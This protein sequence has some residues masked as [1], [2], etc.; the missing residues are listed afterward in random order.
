[1]KEILINCGFIQKKCVITENGEICDVLV[2]HSDGVGGVGNI[3]KGT[4]DNIVPGMQSA[5]IDIGLD[6][7]AFLFASDIVGFNEK[8]DIRKKIKKGDTLTV[9]IVKEAQGVKGARV[10]ENI[11]LPGH[12]LVLMPFMSHIGISKK[13]D[14]ESEKERLHIIVSSLA[15]SN[16]G[17]IVRTD[18]CGATEEELKQEIDYLEEQWEEICRGSKI[19]NSPCLLRSEN[20]LLLTV[21]RDYFDDSVDRLTVNSKEDYNEIMLLAGIMTPDLLS[22]IEYKEG[23]LFYGIESKLKKLLQRRVW[24]D[25]GAYLIIDTTEALT[26]IDVN[27]GK[28]TGGYEFN[29]TIVKTNIAAAKEIAR[30]LRLRAIGG[31]IV[32][33]FIDM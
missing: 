22:R 11:S 21:I 17:Y 15:R 27:T 26:V 24:L 16:H 6:K 30:Q 13:I 9:Q 8:D 31:I 12:R 1:M 10:T 20:G 28:F 25:S 32:I 5:F 18:A 4:V 3:Y 33:D 29:K 14:D 2:E 23:N 19:K 7:N